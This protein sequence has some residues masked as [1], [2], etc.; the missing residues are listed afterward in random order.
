M[1]LLYEIVLKKVF[2]LYFFIVVIAR[3]WGQGFSYSH[4]FKRETFS[5]LFRKYTVI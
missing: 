5:A 2:D 1:R 4:V 3:T